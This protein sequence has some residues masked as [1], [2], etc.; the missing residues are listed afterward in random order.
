MANL[1]VQLK[2]R[3]LAKNTQ[4]RAYLYDNIYTIENTREL[5]FEIVR[6]SYLH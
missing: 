5:V 3:K 6:I 2:G 4:E 1:R